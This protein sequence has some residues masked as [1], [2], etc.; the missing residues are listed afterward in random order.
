[1]ITKFLASDLDHWILVV[2]LS[3][4]KIR[5]SIQLVVWFIWRILGPKPSN[6]PDIIKIPEGNKTEI[7]YLMEEKIWTCSVHK[8]C[9]CKRLDRYRVGHYGI[10]LDV[11]R[12]RLDR[13]HLWNIDD[14]RTESNF[15]DIASMA[16]IASDCSFCY[17]NFVF[18]DYTLCKAFCYNTEQGNNRSIC[19]SK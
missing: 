13:L 7:H 12:R 1:M 5:N 15:N 8:D 2:C 11:E 17:I 9:V 18:Y 16:L 10:D 14:T 6:R 4:I 19:H 3:L